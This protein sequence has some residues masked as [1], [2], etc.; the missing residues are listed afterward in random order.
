MALNQAGTLNRKHNL[1]TKKMSET[2]FTED[3]QKMIDA[4]A[5]K[6]ETLKKDFEKEIKDLTEKARTGLL[7]EEEFKTEKE[8]W[9]TKLKAFDPV[10]FKA[11]GE[12]IIKLEAKVEAIGEKANKGGG[13]RKDFNSI[14]KSF[15]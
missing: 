4:V 14:I 9:E 10:K 15:I 6:N 5:E 3:E 8:E 1:I 13:K 2:K 12:T 7:S 11:Y